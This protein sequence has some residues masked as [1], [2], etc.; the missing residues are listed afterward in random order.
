MFNIVICDDN[1]Q[2]TIDLE[3]LIIRYLNYN[4]FKADIQTF[5]RGGDLLEYIYA[6][7][8]IDLLFLDIELEGK[9]GID[10]AKCLRD[11][12][13]NDSVQI[14]FVSV[15]SNYAIQLFD[16]HPF[17]FLVK[18]LDYRKIEYIMDEYNRLFKF[19]NSFYEYTMGRKTRRINESSIIYFNSVG[20]KINMITQEGKKEFYGKLSDVYKN[21]HSASFCEV[22]KSYIINMRYVSEYDKNQLVMT[23]GDIVPISRNKRDNLNEKIIEIEWGADNK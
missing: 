4:N 12:L 17:N 11:E 13:H 20:K 16:M 19:Q 1:E 8:V 15:K 5:I 22:H 9:T 3:Q 10:I 14:V 18:P 23:N 21:L 6:G 2:F 7:N